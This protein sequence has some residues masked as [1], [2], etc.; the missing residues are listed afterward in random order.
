MLRKSVLLVDDEAAFVAA[1]E[2]RLTKRQLEVTT[3]LSG[4]EALSKLGDDGSSKIDVVILDMKMP[5][6][7]GLETLAEIK[8]AH[9]LLEVI[10]LTGHGT[11]E[12]AIQ[13]MKLGA[14]DYLLK[15]CETEILMA[16]IDEAVKRKRDHE[17][18]ILEARMKMIALQKGLD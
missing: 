16:K 1:M 9:P 15:P 6:M 18:R 7:D 14:A 5:G 11:I 12:S 13:G 3:A 2:R 8:R 17:A 4:A 10:L